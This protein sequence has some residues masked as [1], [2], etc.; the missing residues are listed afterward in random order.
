MAFHRRHPPRKKFCFRV[1]RIAELPAPRLATG[2]LA[3]EDRKRKSSASVETLS[4]FAIQ[5]FLA[6]KIG[7]SGRRS[8]EAVAESVNKLSI[9]RQR[10]R[11]SNA[12]AK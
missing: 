10:L 6:H 2:A 5:P 9:H 12:V 7:F 11:A 4:L 3:V 8:I 1:P